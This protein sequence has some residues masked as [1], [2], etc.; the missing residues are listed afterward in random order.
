MQID[1][2]H[3]AERE[4]HVSFEACRPAPL[5][6]PNHTGDFWRQCGVAPQPPPLRPAAGGDRSSAV[7]NSGGAITTTTI[8]TSSSSSSSS[9]GGG[10]SGGG[11]LSYV[12]QRV[13]HPDGT[14][15]EPV[16]TLCPM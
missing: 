8:T 13:R 1:C 15:R 4:D 2:C 12:T 6:R 10:S 9:N 11:A 3:K 7:A 16:T 5:L 14:W